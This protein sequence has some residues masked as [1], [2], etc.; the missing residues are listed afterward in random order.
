MKGFFEFFAPVKVLA[1]EDALSNLP[2]ELIA[3]NCKK[4]LFITNK[5]LSFHLKLTQD[6]FEGTYI[7]VTTVFDDVPVDSGT[8]C[9]NAATSVYE[10]QQCDSIVAVGGGS[11]LD[12]AKG[13]LMC[14]SQDTRDILSLKGSEQ[15][16]RGNRPFFA[17]L[18]TTAGTGSEATYVAVIKDNTAGKKLEFISPY[19]LP[20]VAVLDAELTKTMPKKL[21]A[22]TG[23]DALVHAIEAYSCLQA[24]PVSDSFALSAIKLI[25]KYLGCAVSAPTDAVRNGMAVAAYLAGIA[26]SNSMVGAVHGIGHSLGAVCGVPHGEAMGIL[27]PHVMQYN[28]EACEEKYAELYLSLA[29]P[30]EIQQTPY[31]FWAQGALDKVCK[32]LNTLYAQCGLP[33]QLSVVGVCETDIPAIVKKALDD[34]AL[35]VNP[36]EM[37]EADIAYI[38]KQAM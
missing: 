36:K 14:I 31:S 2:A 10:Q 3:A 17:A 28:M 6:A 37:R 21:A 4:P 7:D 8:E 11:V 19:L 22:S 1:G 38:L 35:I 33:R 15:I 5:M 12:T 23:I 34:G 16:K 20:D 13:V 32:L 29:A 27:L 26:F 24:N 30:K 9:V 18:P 25:N